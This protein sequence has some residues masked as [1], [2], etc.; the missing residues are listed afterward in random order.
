M[1]RAREVV[2]RLSEELP[3]VR[4]SLVVFAGWPYALLPPT[5][6][7][8][9]VR[10]F[11]QSL[12]VTLVPR[13]DNGTALAEA[14]EVARYTLET[15]PSDEPRQ[16]VLLLSDGG[17]EASE[18]VVEN[19]AWLRG[20]GFEVWVAALGSEAGTPLFVDGAPFL[21]EGGEPVVASLNEPLLR[22]IA[23]A[24]GGRYVDVTRGD[25]LEALL[26]DLRDASGDRETPPPPPVDAAFLLV[27]LA[28]PLFLW[29]ALAD[30]GRSR[31][32]VP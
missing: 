4:F 14:L 11:A 13:T 3:S 18:A 2:A 23:E 28:V 1:A 10:Y 27:L 16:V 12:D 24:G 25:G 5:D 31:K 29:E 22:D 30:F 20:D 21:D 15:R 9:L 26:D 7:P 6:D 8:A 19:A 32:V 17:G